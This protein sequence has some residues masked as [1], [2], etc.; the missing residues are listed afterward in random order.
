MD[1]MEGRV[2][3]VTGAS[4]GIGAAIARRFAREG[5]AVV[6]AARTLDSSTPSAY[7]GSLA[8]T[9]A[10]I[11]KENGRALAVRCDLTIPDDRQRL[12]EEARNAFG[13]IDVLVNNAA[14]SWAKS[15]E[16]FSAKQYQIMFDVHVRSPFELS[17]LVVP[18][19][20]SAG[21]G[22]ILNMTSGAARHP[23]G[24]PYTAED[25]AQTT[26][27]YSMCKVALERFTTG[28]AAHLFDSCIAVN[29]LAP[30]KAVL[31]YGMNHPP[32]DPDRS[33]LIEP[34]DDTAAA[35]LELCTGDPRELTGR[36]TETNE[37]LGR[38]NSGDAGAASSAQTRAGS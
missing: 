18:D 21:R 22:W 37:V 2:A 7:A 30:S 29:A 9:V 14:A 33:D 28:L 19:M 6:M 8:D 26:L 31:T 23:S 20:R 27:V 12:V 36:V 11:R 24:P 34:A 13:P 32:V 25:E 10:T 38:V 1:R 5:A 35:A 17:Q 3:V 16:A 4:R 15:F